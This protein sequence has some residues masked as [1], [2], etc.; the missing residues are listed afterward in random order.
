MKTN[1]EIKAEIMEQLKAHG[2]TAKDVTLSMRASWYDDVITATIRNGKTNPKQIDKIIKS[3]ESIRRCERSGEILNGCNV[4]V[5]IRYA[6]GVKETARADYLARAEELR[7]KTLEYW[8]TCGGACGFYLTDD[9]RIIV[10]LNYDNTTQFVIKTAEQEEKRHGYF[11]GLLDDIA[12]LLL[13]NAC[14]WFGTLEQVEERE[15][16]EKE[17]FEA[18]LQKQEEEKK[19]SALYLQEQER[20]TKLINAHSTTED[21]AEELQPIAPYKWARLN[22]N[23]TLKEYGEEVANG[24]YYTQAGRMVRRWKF[25]NVDAFNWFIKSL[26]TDYDQIKGFG[27]TYKNDKGERTNEVVGVYLF[28]SLQFVIDPQ[29]YGYAR[30]VGLLPLC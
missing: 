28:D 6:E 7:A 16:K 3:Y 5:S 12:D 13:Q 9:K 30:Y 25:E 21:I 2:I 19:E 8:A 1:K 18:Y 29:G 4:Y 24:D 26:L 11:G 23:N 14:G 15:R 27:G 22:K 17:E 20:N 10:F